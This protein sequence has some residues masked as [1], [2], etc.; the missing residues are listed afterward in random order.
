MEK[1][2]VIADLFKH[3]RK[4]QNFTFDNELVKE[5]CSK[6]GFKNPFDVTKLDNTS[7]FPEIL[8]END[9]FILHLGRGKHR[10]VKGIS[11][12]F[13]RFEKIPSQ[14]KINWKYRKSILNEYDTSES[15]IISVSNNQR[16]IHDF[17]YEDIVASPK[18]YS[19][20][21]TN[22]DIDFYVGSEHIEADYVQMEIDFT[23]EMN[24]KVTVFEGKNQFPKDFA[25]Y[26]LYYP[27][28]Y[29]TSLKEQKELKISQITCCYIL[30]KRQ[31][32]GSVLR[33]YNYTFSD[34]DD[35]ASIKLLKSAQYT[36]VK[37]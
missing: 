13:H 29:Y 7:N 16:I 11:N 4:T 20:R 23:M 21:R 31:K 32:K 10:F 34:P 15:N 8:S 5:F 28:R 25:V 14:N 22:S 6:H 35:M 33:L 30:R 18:S 17:L 19:S 2:D 1:K 36:L 3:C 37:R 26:Q 9:Y 24:G 27:F 12:G